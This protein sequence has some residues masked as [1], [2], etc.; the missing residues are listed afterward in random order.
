MDRALDRLRQLLRF[1]E[2]LDPGKSYSLEELAR[3]WSLG[4]EEARK[5]LRKLRREGLIKRT[6]RG[7]YRA[8]LAA[9]A[10]V[11]ALRGASG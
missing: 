4:T 8:S 1:V 11:E 2:P 5:V 3:I 7:R 9:Q 10:L 6:R